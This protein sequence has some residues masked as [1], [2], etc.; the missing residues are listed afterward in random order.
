MITGATFRLLGFSDERAA[1]STVYLEAK[2][3]LDDYTW[4]FEECSRLALSPE[5]S[6]DLLVRVEGDL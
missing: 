2:G 6:R 1:M 5:Q 3:D 4:R